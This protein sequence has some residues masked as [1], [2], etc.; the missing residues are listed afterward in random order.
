MIGHVFLGDGQPQ[1]KNVLQGPKCGLHL[2]A[3]RRGN[4]DLLLQFSVSGAD[5]P[6]RICGRDLYK[7]HAA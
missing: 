2:A 3:I 6:P 4:T 5:A 7:N 1:L